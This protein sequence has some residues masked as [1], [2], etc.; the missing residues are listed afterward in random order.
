MLFFRCK[1]VR[2]FVCI[3]LVD[4]SFVDESVFAYRA[5]RL[6]VLCLL[7]LQLQF[8]V[9]VAAGSGQQGGGCG[10]RAAS[11]SRGRLEA[12]VAPRV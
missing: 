1:L 11:R 8:L 6:S 12:G 9:V 5:G 7:L 3:H 4:D 2:C 10:G